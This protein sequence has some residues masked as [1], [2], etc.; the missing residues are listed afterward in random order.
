MPAF[1]LTCP[2]CNTKLKAPENLAGKSVKCPKCDVVMRVPD[3]EPE[4]VT[5]VVEPTPVAPATP[6]SPAAPDPLS[7]PDPLAAANPLAA[8]GGDFFSA[9]A[10]ATPQAAAS[11]TAATRICPHCE[12]QISATVS[13]CR[14]C[15][16]FVNRGKAAK[17]SRKAAA[18]K[19]AVDD[20]LQPVDYAVSVLLP[21]VGLGLGFLTL[22]KGAANKGLVMIGISGV[23]TLLL[24]GGVVYQAF[25][26]AEPM[27]ASAGPEQGNYEGYGDSYS[28]GGYR[29]EDYGD[30]DEEDYGDYKDG[31][32]EDDEPSLIRPPSDEDLAAQPLPIQRAMRAN[33]RILATGPEGGMAVG[34]GVV[35]E[36]KGDDVFILTNRHVLDPVFVTSDGE[37]G[38]M[39]RQLPDPEVMYVNGSEQDGKIVWFAPK[40]VDL[41]II[42]APCKEDGI[43]VA[44]CVQDPAITIGENVF[45]VGN[46]HGIGWS[47]TKGTVSG[48]RTHQTM[49]GSVPVI[50]TDATINPGNSGGGLYNAKGQLIGINDF[51]IDPSIAR[52]M[53]FAIRHSLFQEL[54]ANNP[55][56]S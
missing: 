5:A 7:A 38:Y 17:K 40:N 10:S 45:A 19:P 24:M 26:T 34:S 31:G 44:D 23:L 6:T 35:I 16:E 27:W 14:F 12:A 15:G 52:G 13:K 36:R 22:S 51:I 28:Q 4:V 55:P 43:E 49:T 2:K 8:P 1:L 30:Y 41:A 25:M 37:T 21:P 46:P 18:T 32:E 11:P 56:Q 3:V 50:Q 20:T 42:K 33:V 54:Y 39:I 9:A 47:L 48:L 53:G 29:D